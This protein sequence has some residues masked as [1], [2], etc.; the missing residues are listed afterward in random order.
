MK[1]LILLGLFLFIGC[2]SRLD[3]KYANILAYNRLTPLNISQVHQVTNSDVEVKFVAKTD[4]GDTISGKIMN[5]IV[6][7]D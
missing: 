3:Y 5:G 4:L 7:K 6:V 2:G 1:R